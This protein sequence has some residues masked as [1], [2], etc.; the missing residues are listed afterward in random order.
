MR[1]RTDVTDRSALL[2]LMLLYAAASL[3]HFTHNAVYLREY[4]NLPDWL[5]ATGVVAAWCATAVVGVVGYWLYSRHSRRAGLLTVGI[6]AAFGFAGLDH[7]VV[8]PIAAHSVMMNLTIVFE[9]ACAAALL[10]FVVYSWRWR[11]G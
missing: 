4:P 3:L 1:E 11:A 2:F 9:V 8:A 6:Y 7:Y 10:A 5:T